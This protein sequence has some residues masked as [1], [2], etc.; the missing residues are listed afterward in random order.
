MSQKHAS[1]IVHRFSISINQL[2][3]INIDCFGLPSI[4]D[5]VDLARREINQ[6]PTIHLEA[7]L[8]KVQ[9]RK[10]EGSHRQPTCNIRVCIKNRTENF[11]R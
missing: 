11:H 2:F 1:S 8:T 3:S 7:Q 10:C 6:L 9:F 4:V 5:F